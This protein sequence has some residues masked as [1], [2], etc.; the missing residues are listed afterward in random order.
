MGTYRCICRKGYE[1]DKTGK[2]CVDIDE[3][4]KH[5][6][7]CIGGRCQNIPGDYQ[8]NNVN[9]SSG[10]KNEVKEIR[11]LGEFIRFLFSAVHLF[12]RYIF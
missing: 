9:V 7:M 3:C 8:V 12:T 11:A 6:L 2:V 5:N 10:K 4:S 1:P